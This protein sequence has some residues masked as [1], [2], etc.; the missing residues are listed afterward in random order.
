MKKAREWFKF[1]GD[2]AKGK[3]RIYEIDVVVDLSELA[4]Y[5]EWNKDMTKVLL[6]EKIINTLGWLIL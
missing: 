5:R 3:D 6:E 1:Y 2:P 4:Y